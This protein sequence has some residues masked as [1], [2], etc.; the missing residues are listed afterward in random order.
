[1]YFPFDRDVFI[2][3][4][5][6]AILAVIISFFPNSRTYVFIPGVLII[7]LLFFFRDPKREVPASCEDALLSPV[8][9]RVLTV[10]QEN[11]DQFI[12]GNA[13][14]I[15]IFLSLKDV[16]INRAPISGRVVFKKVQNGGFAPANNLEHSGHNH[17]VLTGLETQYGKVLCIQRVGVIARRIVNRVKVGDILRAGDK[18]GLMRFGSR[19]DLYFPTSWKIEAKKGDKVKA[20][21]DILAHVN[22]PGLS[23]EPNEDTMD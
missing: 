1:M 2:F 10:D 15:A 18:I 22:C 8:D 16:H 3:I 19:M 17:G 14:H 21:I 4:I 12:H 9:G 20:P 11:E 7:F 6:L 5:P 13:S 23:N